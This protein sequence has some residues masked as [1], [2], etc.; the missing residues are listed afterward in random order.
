[1]LAAIAAKMILRFIAVSGQIEM[2]ELM[3]DLMSS[4]FAPHA[5]CGYPQGLC[6]KSWIGQSARTEPNMSALSDT[7]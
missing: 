6:A 3:V 4:S 5:N 7:D 2:K 1:M